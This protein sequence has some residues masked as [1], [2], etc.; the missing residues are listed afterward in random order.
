MCVFIAFPCVVNFFICIV[1]IIWHHTI[2]LS[3]VC[4]C[5]F[6]SSSLPPLKSVAL[7]IRLTNMQSQ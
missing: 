2:L 1:L 3:C 6:A 5:V 7:T 4:V